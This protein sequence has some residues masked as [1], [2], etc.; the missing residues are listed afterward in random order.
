MDRTEKWCG[1]ITNNKADYCS[2]E[3]HPIRF[4]V[5]KS[6][7]FVSR[8]VATLAIEKGSIALIA[9]LL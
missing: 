1:A 5:E 7:L 2:C 6:A 8:T 4:T 3:E 9:A